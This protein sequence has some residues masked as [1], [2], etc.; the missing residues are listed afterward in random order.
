MWK[1]TYTLSDFLWM[2]EFAMNFVFLSVL[3]EIVWMF[4][5][6][7]YIFTSHQ[8]PENVITGIADDMAYY[9]GFT[10]FKT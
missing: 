3:W 10:L 8:A 9:F 7:I 4:V 6:S 1:F 2:M 5:I